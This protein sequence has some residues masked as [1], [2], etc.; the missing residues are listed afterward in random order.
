MMGT[1]NKHLCWLIHKIFTH[2]WYIVLSSHIPTTIECSTTHLWQEDNALQTNLSGLLSLKCPFWTGHQ[3][4]EA[5]CILALTTP[6]HFVKPIVNLDHF[7]SSDYKA[8][9]TSMLKWNKKV[10]LK[11]SYH[12]LQQRSVT[13]RLLHYHCPSA[14][15]KSSGH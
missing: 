3:A 13:H 1:R 15:S 5:S 6:L 10:S 12:C 2:L 8:L 7:T 9:S 11:N 14:H 4:T